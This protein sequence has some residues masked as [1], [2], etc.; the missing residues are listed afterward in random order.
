MGHATAT[1]LLQHIE[2]SINNANLSLK[3]LIT[4]ASDGPFVNKKVFR[5]LNDKLKSEEGHRIVNI[6]TC[7][8]HIVHNSFSKGLHAEHKTLSVLENE[9]KNATTNL[10]EKGKTADKLIAEA[11]LKMDKAIK[12][13]GFDEVVV[14]QVLL[15][16]AKKARNE[17]KSL[18]R[19]KEDIEKNISYK[20]K[21]MM[22]KFLKK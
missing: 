20:Q 17:E 15:S 22:S 9:L 21:M 16:S 19:K 5:L 12:N 8:I 7:N 2:K 14:S 13:K 1:D 10:N 6:G 18:K 11:T 4:L 3:K